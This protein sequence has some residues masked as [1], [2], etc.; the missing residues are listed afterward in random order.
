M[1]TIN[2]NEYNRSIRIIDYF[3]SL[4]MNLFLNLGSVVYFVP[5]KDGQI[6][7]TFRD[8]KN[9]GKTM[10]DLP[11][12]YYNVQIYIYLVTPFNIFFN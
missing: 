2:N 12:N 7:T 10:D 4:F 6:F 1:F 5:N 9:Y 3:F 11:F 8:V